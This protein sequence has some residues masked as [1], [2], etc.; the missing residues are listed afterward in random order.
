MIVL[1]K[2]KGYIALTSM[3][4]ISAVVLFLVLSITFISISQ[5]I[6]IIG[7]NEA[8]TS[9]YLAEACA[10]YAIIQLQENID[11]SGQEEVEVGNNS[12]YIE[13]I[14]GNGNSDRLIFT[15]SQ[16]NNY[17]SRIKVEIA[18]IRPKTVIKSWQPIIQ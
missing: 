2:Q 9:Y 8:R 16:V 15:K 1:D 5:K 11:Y 14:A 3:L 17:I 6:T 4:I 7:H 13:N 12:C 10:H 18:E